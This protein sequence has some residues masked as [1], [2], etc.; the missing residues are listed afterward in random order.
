[1]R[2]TS[3]CARCSR[4][5]YLQ[6]LRRRSDPAR[7]LHWVEIGAVAGDEVALSS[8]WLRK[9]DL[10]LLGSGQGSARLEDMLRGIADLAQAVADGKLHVDVR[11]AALAEVESM[12]DA[13]LAAGQRLVFTMQ[14]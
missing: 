4:L 12:W 9:A 5:C 8:S 3:V 10:R 1:M 7:A 11:R 13:K 2:P 6:V 14:Q